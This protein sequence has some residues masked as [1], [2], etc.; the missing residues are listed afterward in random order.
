MFVYDVTNYS[1][2]ENLDDWRLYV[3]KCFKESE[4]SRPKYALVA[5]KGIY[6]QLLL[7]VC[8]FDENYI[9]LHPHT[10]IYV[11]ECVLYVMCLCDVYM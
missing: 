3:D 8:S 6:E 4:S 11:N 10:Y 2:F 1:S 7:R 5:N 9:F